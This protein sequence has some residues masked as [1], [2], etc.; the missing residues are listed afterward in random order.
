MDTC[1]VKQLK[2]LYLQD[3]LLKAFRVFLYMC[4]Y[5]YKYLNNA[6]I[7]KIYRIL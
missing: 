5:V 4:I 7:K 3:I 6:F 2:V 1:T